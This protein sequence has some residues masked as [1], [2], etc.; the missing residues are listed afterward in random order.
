MQAACAVLVGFGAGLL[1]AF[2]AVKV[3]IVDGLRA[4]G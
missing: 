1:P 2:N 3:R 4:G